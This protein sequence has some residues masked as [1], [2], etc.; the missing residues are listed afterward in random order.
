MSGGQCVEDLMKRFDF[1]RT[2]AKVKRC[3]LFSAVAWHLTGLSSPQ[4]T[5]DRIRKEGV[6]IESERRVS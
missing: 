5:V 2:L 4:K 1:D 3:V 6:L